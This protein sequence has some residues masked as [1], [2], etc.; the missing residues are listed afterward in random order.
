MNRRSFL[1]RAVALAVLPAL[2]RLLRVALAENADARRVRPGDPSWPSEASW[3][4]LNDAVGGRLI[5]VNS[6]LSACREAPDGAA[7]GDLFRELK[8]PYYIGDNVALTQTAGWV[9]AWES[10]PSVYAVAAESTGD[11]VAAVNFARECNLRLV[12]KG[13]GHSYQGTLNAADSY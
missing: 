13:G 2:P 4:K 6:P 1:R 5:K 9:D 12:G 3:A 10:H 8:N 7:C 11:V